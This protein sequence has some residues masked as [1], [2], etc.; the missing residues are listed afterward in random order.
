MHYLVRIEDVFGTYLPDPPLVAILQSLHWM[1]I[2]KDSHNYTFGLV[3]SPLDAVSLY[4][5]IVPYMTKDQ[6][7]FVRP[8]QSDGLPKQQASLRHWVNEF[9]QKESVP[10]EYPEID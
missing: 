4:H 1:E 9:L 8:V 2:V 10:G 3:Q 6:R 5:Q 7:L